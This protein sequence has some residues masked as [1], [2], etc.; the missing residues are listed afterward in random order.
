MLTNVLAD[1]CFVQGDLATARALYEE[2]LALWRELGAQQGIGYSL[3]GLGEVQRVDGRPTAARAL[4]EET[5][6]VRRALGD[7]PN[8]AIVL[9]QLG[10]VALDLGDVAE[11]RGRFVESLS[12]S[13]DVGGRRGIALALEGLA[14]VAV[15][16][17]RRGSGPCARRVAAD[18]VRT[19]TAA[20]S[21]PNWQAD[22]TVGSAQRG[23]PS[24][25]TGGR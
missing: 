13:R 8:I 1:A 23:T 19:A 11:A 2:G 5:L 9:G 3:G 24:V 18:A 4:Y 6:R 14:V 21:P 16:E 17:G 7:R 15:T 10:L 20:H 22:P 12:L 25:A